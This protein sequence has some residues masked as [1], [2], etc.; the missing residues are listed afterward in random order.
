[1]NTGFRIPKKLKTVPATK[2]VIIVSGIKQ[3]LI[4]QSNLLPVLVLS[5]ATTICFF[6]LLTSTR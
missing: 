3:R 2:A 1:M 4:S 6:T 5:N